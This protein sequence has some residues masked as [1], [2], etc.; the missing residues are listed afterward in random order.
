[1]THALNAATA[2]MHPEQQST[3]TA[4][5]QAPFTGT[6]TSQSAQVMG[7]IKSMRDTFEKN[8]ADAITTEKNSKEAYDEFMK[9]K[10]AAY[11]EMKKSYE[12]KQKSLGGND[13]TLASK[14]K[15]LA[16]SQKQKQSDEDF[17]ESLLPLCEKKGAQYAKRKVL[18]ANEE[19]AI[20]QAISI[21]NSD[22][23]FAAFG[24]TDATK[25]G[26]TGSLQFIQLR[27]VHKHI[28]AR[29][30]AQKVLA[31]A[32][33]DVK[34]ARLAKVVALLQAD[35][36]FDEV[37]KEIDNMIELIDEEGKADQTKFDWCAKERKEKKATVADKKK[38]ILAINKAIDQ[39]DKD[40]NDP[41]EGFKA[42]IAETEQNLVENTESQTKQTGERAEANIAYQQ[43][44]KNLVK[45]QSILSKAIKVLATYYDDLEAKLAEGGAFLQKREDPAPPKADLNMEGQSSK[46]GDVV[47]MLNFILDEAKAEETEA[48]GDEESAQADYEDSMTKL[49]KQ[50]ADDEKS[51]AK[52]QDNLAQ[53]EKD[54]LDAE[55]DLK[56]TTED[57]EAAEDYLAKIKPGCD[58]IKSN[59]ELRNKN[60][61]T[62]KAALNKATGLIKDTP[63]YKSAVNAA[64]VESYGKCEEPCVADEADV[65][66]K[67]C[68]VDVTIPAYC[69][70]HEGTKGC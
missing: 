21:L 3:A 50:Q 33:K 64:T 26:S 28:D 42:Q 68:M 47:G 65:K 10:K 36:V 45:A 11:K 2:L 44:V 39:L 16:E 57:K 9:L 38:S 49:K 35:N 27:S 52:L 55:E 24:K 51:L 14:R 70:G 7:M 31:S 13:K 23:A 1:L 8:L 43:D 62:E 30:A 19:A 58:F 60:R 18:R 48:H 41:K 29:S 59:F 40:I 63:A 69:A 5:L 12:T 4:F 53:A 61:A 15:Q 17:L 46:G 32:A 67:A 54:L 20:A 6:Y 25:S 34:S 56:A 37:L 66:C 22:D